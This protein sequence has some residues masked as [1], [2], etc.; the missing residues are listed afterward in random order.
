MNK[1][2]TNEDCKHAPKCKEDPKGKKL[3][4]KPNPKVCQGNDAIECTNDIHCKVDGCKG[5]VCNFVKG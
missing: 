4:D 2:F 1:C 3:P 5:K